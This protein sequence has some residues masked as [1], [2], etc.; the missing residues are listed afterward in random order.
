MKNYC[1]QTPRNY[2]QRRFRPLS[3]VWSEFCCKGMCSVANELQCGFQATNTSF[4]FS[5]THRGVRP[6]VQVL[7]LQMPRSFHLLLLR[8]TRCKFVWHES[9]RARA[10]KKAS[11]TRCPEMRSYQLWTKKKS[12]SLLRTGEEK[13]PLQVR[14]QKGLCLHCLARSLFPSPGAREY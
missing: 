1:L 7:F 11:L 12:E 13:W 9:H 3:R 10:V 14:E 4:F 8:Q 2:L 5:S 6:G